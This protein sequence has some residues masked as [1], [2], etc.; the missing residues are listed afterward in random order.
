MD[1]GEG[2][3]SDKMRLCGARSLGRK[4]FEPEIKL[5]SAERGCAR[6]TK[7]Q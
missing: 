7:E 4:Y 3:E 6:R 5:G 1:K 2:V